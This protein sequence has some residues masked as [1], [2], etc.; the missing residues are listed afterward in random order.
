MQYK[1]KDKEVIVDISKDKY[2][3]SQR[4]NEYKH[5]GAGDFKGLDVSAETM[6]NVTA[7][8]QSLDYNGFVFPK[9]KYKQPEDNLADFIMNSKEVDNYYKTHA[10]VLYRDYKAGKKTK[11][12]KGK[13]IAN[14]YTPNE[15]HC[16][17]AFAVNKWLGCTADTF[18]ENVPIWTIVNELLEGRSCVVSGVFN[19]LNHIVSLVG[20]KWG[21]SNFEG[22]S[23]EA[24]LNL[25]T[26][27]KVRPTSFIIDDPYGNWKKGYQAG[28]SGNNSELS[29]SEFIKM[30]KPVDNN[31]IKM[32]HLIK[33]GA[34]LI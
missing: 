3:Y 30:I 11:N 7:L 28:F 9:G 29:Y 1:S 20:C 18:K 15:V 33:N 19:G 31:L 6:C 32:C 13:E 14:Y 23:L 27:N 22:K 8:C 17:L 16:V 5:Y 10:P 2:N 34:A 25:I 26:K 21:Y 4:N 12:K 24:C